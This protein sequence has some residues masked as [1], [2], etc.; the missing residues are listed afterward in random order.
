MLV[1]VKPD[2]GA[3][4][5][6]QVTLGFKLNAPKFPNFL[7]SINPQQPV[8]FAVTGY[9]KFGFIVDRLS[10]DLSDVEN[11]PGIPGSYFAQAGNDQPDGEV[12]KWRGVYIAQLK[13]LLPSEFKERGKRPRELALP[14]DGRYAF[15][16]NG[17]SNDLAVV[18]LTT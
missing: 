5:P 6:G 8:A 7:I 10:L 13:V 2:D 11:P 15:M 1:P 17:P 9:E 4:L 3:V 14:A 18:D 16:A 12:N